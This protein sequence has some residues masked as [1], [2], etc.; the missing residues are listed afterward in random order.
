MEFNTEKFAEEALR[1]IQGNI[2]NLNTLNIIVVGKTG[3]GKSTLINSV[4]REDLATEG[5]G[6]PVTDHMSKIS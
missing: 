6:K 4:F 1:S 5:M 2:A 3:A